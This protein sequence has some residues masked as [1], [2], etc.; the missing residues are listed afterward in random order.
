MVLK[1]TSPERIRELKQLI[2]RHGYD[3]AGTA[4][5]SHTGSLTSFERRG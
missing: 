1:G 2:L 4:R 3:W 5:V